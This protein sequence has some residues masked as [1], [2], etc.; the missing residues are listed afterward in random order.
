MNTESPTADAKVAELLF[1]IVVDS[2]G[3]FAIAQD[4]D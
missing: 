2:N 1:Y 4:R 3:E